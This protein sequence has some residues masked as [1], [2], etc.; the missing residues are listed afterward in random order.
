MATEAVTSVA[1]SPEPAPRFISL[2]DL[3]LQLV[4]SGRRTPTRQTLIRR[5]AEFA[6]R[7][8][9]KIHEVGRDRYVST[10][11]LDRVHE[12]SAA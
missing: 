3:G 9:L 7:N 8:G 5:G 12:G 4:D 10:A 11:E 6:G 1:T 2:Y